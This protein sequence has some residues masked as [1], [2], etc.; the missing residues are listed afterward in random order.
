MIP[1]SKSG[2]TTTSAYCSV[3]AWAVYLSTDLLTAMHPPNAATL[4][5][6]F[7]FYPDP[8]N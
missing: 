8:Q 6:M 7:A 2:A 3:M 5:A 4:S 1:S